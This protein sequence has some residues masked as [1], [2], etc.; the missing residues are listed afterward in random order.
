[1][2]IEDLLKKELNFKTVKATNYR[3]GGD[4]SS[5]QTFIVDNEQKVFVK[6]NTGR[7]AQLMFNGELASLQ[8]IENTKTIRV[9]KP[10]GVLQDKDTHFIVME[11]LDLGY[12]SS[13][14][15]AKLGTN[16]AQMHLYNLNQKETN[17]SYVSKFGFDVPTCCG[18]IAQS[19]TWTDSWVEFYSAKLQE[20]IDLV[21]NDDSELEKVWPKLKEK[22]PDFFQDI[23]VK[24]SLLHGDLWSG[25]AGSVGTEPVI[26]DAASFYGHH[27]Y[28]L[29]IAGM[30]GGFSSAFYSAYHTLIPKETGFEKRHL[31][32]QLFH[33]LNHWNHFGSG[34]RSGSLSIMKKL[35]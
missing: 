29:G 24:P 6:S 4:I 27:E 20:Q 35:L 31:L 33:H 14:I 18:S 32:Y 16:L 34:Y 12:G 5:G 25:N 2:K 26:Y 15:Q 23:Q 21:S 10:Y 1:M 17:P 28:D 3:R 13:S 7:N 30:F 8:A 9:P 22:I 11:H 19:N